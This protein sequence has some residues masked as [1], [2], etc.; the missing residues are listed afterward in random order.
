MF[1]NVLLFTLMKVKG[2]ESSPNS[3]S[4]V[5]EP[6]PDITAHDKQSLRTP[7]AKGKISSV[8]RKMGRVPPYRVPPSKNGN[9]CSLPIC[10][11]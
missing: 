11:S 4:K 10:K 1:V 9:F 8:S 5:K 3:L 7:A 2:K 6:S